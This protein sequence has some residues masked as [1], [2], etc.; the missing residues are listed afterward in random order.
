MIKMQ[1]CLNYKDIALSSIY[2]LSLGNINV[3]IDNWIK[4]V[5]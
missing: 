5:K 1:V 2:T 4:Y 3:F